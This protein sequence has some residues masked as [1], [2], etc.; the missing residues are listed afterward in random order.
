MH[1]EERYGQVET[2]SVH[3]PFDQG[4]EKRTRNAQ[5]VFINA[6]SVRKALAESG[7]EDFAE[8]FPLHVETPA[9]KLKRTILVQDIPLIDEKAPLVA[10]FGRYGKIADLSLKT[11]PCAFEQFKNNVKATYVAHIVYTT[12][13]SAEKAL[14]E[15]GKDDFIE[16]QKLRVEFASGDGN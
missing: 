13:E 2:I 1:F 15:D 4:D 16:G 6:E 9:E 7:K 5:L 10:H 14:V 12:A 8:S 3:A 11:T